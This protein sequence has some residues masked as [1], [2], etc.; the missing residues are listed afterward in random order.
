RAT[1]FDESV[2]VNSGCIIPV[3]QGTVNG[4]LLYMLT[5]NSPITV[6]SS[7]LTFSRIGGIGALFNVVEDTTPQLGGDLDGNGFEI[8]LTNNKG[9]KGKTAAAAT[10]SLVTITGAD[11]ATYGDASLAAAILGTGLT[12][13]PNTT[14]SGTLAAAGNIVVTGNSP[15][16]NVGS[17]GL[18]T[19]NA[20]IEL[21]GRTGDGASI[22]DFHSQNAS[23]Y[24]TR[25]LRNSG[26]N[27]SFDIQHLGT[28]VLNIGAVDVAPVSISTQLLNRIYVQAG[29]IVNNVSDLVVGRA[30]GSGSN[31]RLEAVDNATARATGFFS[32]ENE[33]FSSHTMYIGSHAAAGTGWN[34]SLGQSDINGTPDTEYVI[35]GDGNAFIDGAWTGGGADDATMLEWADGNPQRDDRAGI[36]VVLVADKIRPAIDT[37]DPDDIVGVVSGNPSSVG[38]T[39]G[40]K[41]AGRYERDEFGRYKMTEYQVY[42][43]DEVIPAVTKIKQRHLKLRVTK[44]VERIAIVDGRAILSIEE[45]EVSAPQYA[46]YFVEDGAGNPVLVKISEATIDKEGKEIVPAQYQQA[47]HREPIL[48]DYEDIIGTEKTIHHSHADYK[49]P[50]GVVPPPDAKVTV[51]KR[52]VQSEDFDPEKAKTYKDRLSRALE[53]GEWAAIGRNG[54]VPIRKGQPV[55]PGWKLMREISA[56]VDLWLIN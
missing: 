16:L 23:D 22:L 13:T 53:Y 30:A 25:L 3:E 5:T 20:I 29:G 41:W 50:E 45:Q 51:Q 33:S 15:T 54:Q 38:N 49:M 17:S 52:R 40:C 7:S 11:V 21:G 26:A 36:S 43:W 46:E 10:K 39:A 42:E 1:D 34:F 12:I 37:D 24:D 55:K 8:I 6:G 19:G 4:D 56:A 48:E 18:S 32:S 35:R 27:G 14:I 44:T 2:E 28:G 31:G 47:M 9:F